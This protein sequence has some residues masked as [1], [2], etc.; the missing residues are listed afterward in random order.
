MEA[1]ASKRELV[2]PGACSGL[3][4]IG[5][6]DDLSPDEIRECIN[7]LIFNEDLQKWCGATDRELLTIVIV[8]TK[9]HLFNFLK[10]YT[11][12]R[13]IGE[14]EGLKEPNLQIE[15]EFKDTP[16]ERIGIRLIELLKAYNKKVV[17]E[18]LLYAR[19][20]PLEEG[21]L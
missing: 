7:Q 20:A 21:T 4:F 13:A 8:R 17:K 19:T 12:W 3:C 16:D 5:R 9:A 14:W 2:H 10:G 1:T 15:I 6:P 11:R 18:E